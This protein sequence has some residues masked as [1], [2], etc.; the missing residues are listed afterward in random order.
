[1][2]NKLFIYSLAI[3]S[4]VCLSSCD[5]EFLDPSAASET[6]V[7]NDI[8]G[9][10]A[11]S[12]GLPYRYSVGRAS[13]GY[14][15]PVASGL[16]TKELRVLNAGN[17]DED[18]LE[19]GGANVQG[20]NSIVRNI[21][22]QSNL[23]KAN[24]DIILKNSESITDAGTKSG[25]QSF[26]NLFKAMALGALGEFFEQATINTAAGASFS[27]RTDVL[28]EAIRLLEVA[29]SALSA[30][31]PSAF[32]TSRIV[33]GI[34]MPNTIQALIARYNLM[35]GDYDKALAA[36]NKVDLTKKSSFSF[37]DVSRNAIFDAVM[38]NRNVVEP[39]NTTMGLPDAIKPD[40]ADK[41]LAFF[42]NTTA[43][44]NLGRASFYTGNASPVP[45]YRPGEVILIK[46]ESYARKNQLTEAI[47]ELNKVLTKKAAADAWGIGADLPA[48]AGANTADA[49]LTEIYRQ[50]C[51]ELF[52]TGL[53]LDD[54]RRFNRPNPAE[55]TR[56]FYPYPL[57][58]RDNNTNTPVD[59]QG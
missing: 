30:N 7:V 12:N 17:A 31:A 24:A 27:S 1:M 4:L 56:N 40:P 44:L 53:K 20:N 58:E 59:P 10:I 16:S 33:A 34:D 39:T 22:E 49:I 15:M 8:T 28:K 57:T 25:I 50:R 47:A 46:A 5:N 32:F 2:K 54:S 43:G 18:F 36:A 48:Y 23:I 6:Q 37:D 21:W 3:C 35:L 52:L 42:L 11:L 45:V 9:L 19:K 38:S 26:A 13:L 55:R 14:T 29:G 51:I 41:R